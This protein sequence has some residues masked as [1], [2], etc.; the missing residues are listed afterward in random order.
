[1]R[2]FQFENEYIFNYSIGDD[3]IDSASISPD[4]PRSEEIFSPIVETKRS[5]APVSV[6]AGTDKVDIEELT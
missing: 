5:P 4:S 3:I 2:I 1:V 6:S